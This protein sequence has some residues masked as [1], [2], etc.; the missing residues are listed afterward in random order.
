VLTGTEIGSFR[1][2]GVH[3]EDLLRRVLAETIVPRI[4]ISSLQPH[5]LTPGLLSLWKDTRLC[6]HFHI[7][8]QSGS[9]SVLSRMKRGYSAADYASALAAIRK[10]LPG[11][12]ITT[13]VIVGFP[14]ETESEFTETLDY[15]RDAGFARFHIFPF[16]S[17]PGTAAAS[18]PGHV[19]AKVKKERGSCLAEAGAKAALDFRS[20]KI[21][22]EADVLWEHATR[23]GEYSGY[24]PD[25]IRVYA[26]SDCDITNTISPV[27]LAKLYR[28]GAWCEIIDSEENR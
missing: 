2:A 16:S 14:G 11:A 10:V 21:G 7:S 4:R 12:A 3:F 20:N 1:S 22:Q 19:S 24:T 5:E 17:R 8:L 18:M 6:P 27:R 26:R 23:S 9:D 25:Y 28:D 13:D 15:C